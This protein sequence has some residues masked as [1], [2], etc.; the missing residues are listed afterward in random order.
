MVEQKAPAASRPIDE[1]ELHAAG[2]V[3]KSRR[4]HTLHSTPR[5]GQVFW[6]NFAKD[7]F[8]PEFEGEHPAVVVRAARRLSDTCII[9]PLTHR[10]QVENP[11][12]LKLRRNP[13]KDDPEDAWAVCDHIYTVALGRLRRMRTRKG[14]TAPVAIDSDDLASIFSKIQRVLHVVFEAPKPVMPLP[15]QTRP[16][17][18]RT[19]SL[20]RSTDRSGS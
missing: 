11:H 10:V 8:S 17:G 14:N 6:V 15:A 2:W 12:A 9:V 1:A 7:N 19:L 13:N 16:R 5:V 4:S 20:P 3:R 18:P